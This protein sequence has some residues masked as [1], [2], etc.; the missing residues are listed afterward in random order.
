MLSLP[1]I[2]AFSF[3]KPPVSFLKWRVSFL[4]LL[5]T[6]FC[7]WTRS[8]SDILIFRLKANIKTTI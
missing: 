8:C 1:P 4:K 6:A 5:E 2:T 7:G 3:L